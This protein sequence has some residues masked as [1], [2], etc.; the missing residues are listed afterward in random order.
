M[1]ANIISGHR[2]VPTFALNDASEGKTGVNFVLRHKGNID[3]LDS[4]ADVEMQPG[5]TFCV[6]TPGG[7]GY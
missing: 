7:G 1:Q 6:H 3:W 4:C 2:R 5:D